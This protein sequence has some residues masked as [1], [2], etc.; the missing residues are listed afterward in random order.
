MRIVLARELGW[1][2]LAVDTPA[3]GTEAVLKAVLASTADGLAAISAHIDVAAFGA[4][5]EAVAAARRVLFVCAGPTQVVCQDAMFDLTSIDRPAE[6]SADTVTQ[7]LSASKLGAGDVC[8]AA[9]IS[10]SNE[11][12]IGAART[13][14]DAGATV[15]V[16]TGYPRSELARLADIA[17]VVG[18]PDVP[19]G[20]HGTVGL[21]GMLVVLRALTMAVAH[22]AE[23]APTSPLMDTIA[24]RRG[25][26]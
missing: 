3:Q 10:G 15:I 24:A 21:V 13:A 20:L 1:A 16:L 6:F 7:T 2:R 9:G 8:F 12:T 14:L 11:L 18:S 5:V 23:E 25:G 22:L 19:D 4:A 17:L 26:W